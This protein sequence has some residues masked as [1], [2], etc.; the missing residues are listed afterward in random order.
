M[1]SE[2]KQIDPKSAQYTVN[3]ILHYV[4]EAWRARVSLDML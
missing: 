3:R 4:G 1:L 2:T